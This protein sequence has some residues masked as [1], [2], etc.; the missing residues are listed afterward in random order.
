[1][2]L[3][4]SL[5]SASPSPAPAPPTPARAGPGRRGP[6]ASCRTR[7]SAPMRALGEPPARRGRPATRRRTRVARWVNSSI[8]TTSVTMRS[9]NVRSWLTSTTPARHAERPSARGGRARRG[10]GRWSARRAGTRRSVTAAARRARRAPPRRP[11]ATRSAGRAVVGEAELVPHL[12]DPRLEVG[13]AERQPAVQGRV[14]PVVGAGGVGRRGRRSPASRSQLRG[15]D[16]GAAC[17]VRADRLVVTRSAPG[18]GSRPWRS[19][20]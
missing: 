2:F 3:S 15:G 12:A 20:A 8:S 18:A 10:R 1:M 5:S 16:A 14:V 11:T 19:A 9:R 13:G 17:E 4:G 6:C 7:R